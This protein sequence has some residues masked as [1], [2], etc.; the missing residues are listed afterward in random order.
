MSTNLYSKLSCDSSYKLVQ[1]TPDLLK[2]LTSD[3]PQLQFKSFDDRKSDV[4]LCS[5]RKSW[6]LRQKNHSNTVMLMRDFLPEEDKP[7]DDS[8]LFGMPRPIN[9]LL[10]YSKTTYEYETRPTEGR[11]NLDLVPIY[12]GEINFPADKSKLKGRTLKDVFDNSPSSERECK[13]RW[14]YL[15]GCVISGYPCILS[16]DLLSNALHVTVM[17][18]LAE[19][20]DFDRLN[21]VETHQAVQ[22]D[23]EEDSSPYVLEVIKT[24]LAKFGTENDDGTW[25]LNKRQVAQWYG[26]RAL[27]KFASRHSAP[28]EEFLIKWKSTF[29]PFAP[30]DIDMKMLKG[31]FYEPTRGNIQYV[32]K[33][34]LPID[35]KDRFKMLFKLQSQWDLDAFAPFVEDLNTK[36]LKIDNF[37]MKY[38][39]KRRVG[40]KIVVCSRIS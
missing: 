7:L 31:W 33:D 35:V 30:F 23:V 18:A 24:V 36:G 16:P 19:S 22:K 17:S 9:D 20:L 21:P 14:Y 11:I 5:A 29:P 37:I 39:R 3:E 28:I 27:Q 25:T 13:L 2:A 4:V 34:T 8:A 32:S 26:I 10:G 38:A 40:K 6:L 15:G 12:N 1:L